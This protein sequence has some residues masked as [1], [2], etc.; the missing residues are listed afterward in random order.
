MCR[1]MIQ[2]KFNESRFVASDPS[3][4][5][6]M[7]LA[8]RLLHEWTEDVTDEDTG[9]II[10]IKRYDVL[11]ERGTK[12]TP[13]VAISINFH[14]QTGE[15]CEFEVT[16]QCRVG[17]YD[18]GDYPAPW[19][20]TAHVKGKNRKFIL[21]AR[22]V[23]EA[24]EIATDFIEQKMSGRFQFVSVKGYND[25]IAITDNFNRSGF[26]A[27]R[28]MP[29]DDGGIIEE[30]AKVSGKFYLIELHITPQDG[31]EHDQVFLVFTDDAEK[32]KELANNWL[33]KRARDNYD[34]ALA[35]GVKNPERFLS[36][37]TTINTATVVNC[38]CVIPPDFS[39]EYF[40]QD[41]PDGEK[42]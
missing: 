16:D 9:E 8:D 24:I 40:K 38:Y 20:V 35:N 14:I 36:F 31:V 4:V 41:K 42:E 5:I 34:E 37:T 33:A 3:E 32:A 11:M 13:D 10:S 30:D 26:E 28:E 25:C 21:Y 19:M 12:I 1:T 6:G 22:G 29:E 17:F 7:F 39:R 15:I 23:E 18:K 27:D 2:T